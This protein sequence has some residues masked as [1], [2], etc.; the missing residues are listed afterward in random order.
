LTIPPIAN[1]APGCN[2]EPGPDELPTV[3]AKHRVKTVPRGAAAANA[4]KL[5]S[6]RDWV[7]NGCRM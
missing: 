5:V 1:A 3:H 7:S 2:V 4:E 6:C